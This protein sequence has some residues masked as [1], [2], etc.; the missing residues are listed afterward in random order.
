MK[1]SFLKYFG[2]ILSVA[3]LAFL[4]P[5]ALKKF[6]CEIISTVAFR[7]FSHGLKID[8][9]AER[10]STI[11]CTHHSP[12]PSQNVEVIHVYVAIAHRISTLSLLCDAQHMCTYR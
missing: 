3:L 11:E 4:A 9:F 10:H 2:D 8:V 12:H 5:N 6:F 7:P 1:M